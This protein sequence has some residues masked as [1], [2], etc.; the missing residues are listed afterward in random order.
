MIYGK[1]SVIFKFQ[2]VR[3]YYGIWGEISIRVGDQFEKK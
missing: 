3:T 2:Y 1:L